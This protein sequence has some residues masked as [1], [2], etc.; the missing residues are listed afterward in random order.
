MN[1]RAF[2][3][4]KLELIGKNLNDLADLLEIHRS[5]IYK[6]LEGQYAIN[7][8]EQEKINKYLDLTKDEQ[9]KLWQQK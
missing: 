2:V 1:K 7:P 8:E 3:K 9:K 6:K 4:Y 5:S